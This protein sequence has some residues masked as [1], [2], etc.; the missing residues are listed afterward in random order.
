LL[1]QQSSDAGNVIHLGLSIKPIPGKNRSY[2]R[3]SQA[4][5]GTLKS[6]LGP[7]RQREV[8]IQLEKRLD[9]NL[10]SLLSH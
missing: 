3:E 5:F 10:Y 7:G 4:E 6:A 2:V 9:V 8:E 1:L